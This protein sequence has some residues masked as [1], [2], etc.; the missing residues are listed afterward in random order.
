MND[1]VLI[2]FISA[3][4]AGTPLL[5]VY[6]AIA[7]CGRETGSTSGSAGPRRPIRELVRAASLAVQTGPR[8]EVLS[9]RVLNGLMIPTA[10]S[11]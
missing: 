2:A 6:P 8:F 5:T 11:S 1:H 9:L 3:P 10:A 7:A 4:E